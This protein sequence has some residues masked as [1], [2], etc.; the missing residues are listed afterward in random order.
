M[1]SEEELRRL[2]DV[3]AEARA[4]LRALR[5]EKLPSSHIAES[6]ITQHHIDRL[7]ELLGP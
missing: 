7:T 4:L 1:T 6:I 2:R 5:V 3:E